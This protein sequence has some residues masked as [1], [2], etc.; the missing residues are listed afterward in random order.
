MRNLE[1]KLRVRKSFSHD[2]DPIILPIEQATGSAAAT[3]P[4]V[5]RDS[6]QT[7]ST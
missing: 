2:Y 7:P 4:N 3:V 6:A 1:V 5:I